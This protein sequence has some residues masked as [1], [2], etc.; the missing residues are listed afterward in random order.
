MPQLDSSTYIAQIFWLFVS[1]VLLYLFIKYWFVPRVQKSLSDRDNKINKLIIEAERFKEQTR[2]MKEK[3]L[4]EMR[5]LNEELNKINLA[6]EDFC[7][8]HRESSLLLLN[9]EFAKHKEEFVAKLHKWQNEFEISVEVSGIDLSKSLFDTV[10]PRINS[11]ER[12][13]Q[14]IKIDFSKYYN[15]IKNEV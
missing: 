12:S 14:E 10:M 9:H 7:T 1:F 15:K 4:L 6:T 11:K 8:K 13:T 5:I 2:K 3:H